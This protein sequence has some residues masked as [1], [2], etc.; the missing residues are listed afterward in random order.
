MGDYDDAGGVVPGGLRLRAHALFQLSLDRK[1]NA[2][3]HFIGDTLDNLS[4]VIL[5]VNT[6]ASIVSRW[7]SA[8]CAKLRAKVAAPVTEKEVQEILHREKKSKDTRLARAHNKPPRLNA[9]YL[10]CK[11][12]YRRDKATRAQFESTRAFFQHAYGLLVQQ[13]ARCAISNILMM[14]HI[15]TDSLAFQPSL[16]AIVPAK[17]H[18]KGNLRWVCACLNATD[19]SKGN[20]H[21]D[22]EPQSWTAKLFRTYI[23]VK[24]SN[25]FF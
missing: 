6:T 22:G 3:P 12:T 10:A 15:Y 18:V 13:Q 1:D 24:K 23:S 19:C 16:D 9:V 2:R 11:A 25:D 20:A 5:G 21:P 8:T 17:G 7:G 4:F 14:D